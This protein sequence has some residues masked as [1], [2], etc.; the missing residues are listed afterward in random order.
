MIEL[1]DVHKR[2]WTRHRKAIW[3]LRGVDVSFRPNRNVAII[4]APKSGRSTLL[5]VIA[6]IEP[7]TRGEVV[8]KRRV[9]WPIGQQA[10]LQASMSGRQNA[11]FVCR[12]HGF[13][14]EELEERLRFVQ[15]FSEIGEAFDHPVATY[16]GG[17]RRRLTFALSVAFD[18]EVYLLESR[19]LRTGRG[20]FKDKAHNA[21][22]F[23]AREAD[24]IFVAA[25]ERTALSYGNAGLW[26]HEGKAHWFESVAEAWRE[27]RKFSKAGTGHEDTEDEE[28]EEELV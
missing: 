1:K 2:Y 13:D 18:F 14:G 26:L 25:N 12:L 27:H 23:L 4:G 7:P 9:S 28:E 16:L 24:L 19:A 21:I 22:R 3:A 15:A 8:C 11:R 10:G 20:D 5:R 6:G 17:E